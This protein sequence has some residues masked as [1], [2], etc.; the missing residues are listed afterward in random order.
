MPL[1]AVARYSRLSPVTSRSAVIR[2]TVLDIYEQ[3]KRHWEWSK[4]MMRRGDKCSLKSSFHWRAQCE[5]RI[6]V[7][8]RDMLP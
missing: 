5:E 4:R 3:S 6:R 7:T 8:H 1:V 2:L